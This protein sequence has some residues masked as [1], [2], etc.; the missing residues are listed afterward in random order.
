MCVKCNGVYTS[1]VMCESVY[2]VG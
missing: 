2:A 1:L